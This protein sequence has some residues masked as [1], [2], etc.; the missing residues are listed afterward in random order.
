MPP[1][2]PI[3]LHVD[4]SVLAN[5]A[6][7][8]SAADSAALT[9]GG[10]SGVGLS[11]VRTEDGL[12]ISGDDG[13]WAVTSLDIPKVVLNAPERVIGTIATALRT[14]Q[15]DVVRSVVRSKS[16]RDQNFD[17]MCEYANTLWELDDNGQE[18]DIGWSAFYDGID[19]WFSAVGREITAGQQRGSVALGDAGIASGEGAGMESAEDAKAIRS[20]AIDAVLSNARLR[21]R[22]AKN[23]ECVFKVVCLTTIL[24][25]RDRVQGASIVAW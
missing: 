12:K 15:L 17:S 4:S 18:K 1:T 3:R 9:A 8:S 23:S 25:E 13:I 10:A 21:L 24:G 16:L 6:L 20:A 2:C 11:C 22:T 19:R 7:S 5:M 14:I